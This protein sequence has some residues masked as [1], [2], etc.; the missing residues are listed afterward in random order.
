MKRILVNGQEAAALPA[1]DLG[2]DRGIAIFETWRTYGSAP[3]RLE[4][5]WAR[6]SDSANTMGIEL[7]D[8]QGILNEISYTLGQDVSQRLTLTGSGNRILRVQP[9]DQDRVGRPIRLGTLAWAGLPDLPGSVKHCL[10]APWILASRRLGVDEVLLVDPQGF[11]LEAN[12]SNVFAVV[13]GVLVTPPADGRI[14]AGVT[15]QALLDAAVQA[16]LPLEVR[17]VCRDER[18]QE[19]YV[20]STLKELAPVSH[21]DDQPIGEGPQGRALYAAFRE[22]VLRESRAPR[23]APAS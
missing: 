8:Y 5:H 22:L 7:P 23:A 12:R 18:F 9:I 3:F 20:S 13:D 17:P 10:R 11:L 2:L 14:L 15:R 19:L 21:L 6:L 16:G 4:A 1:D